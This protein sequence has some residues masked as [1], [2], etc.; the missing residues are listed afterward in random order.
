MLVRGLQKDP[1]HNVAFC[2]NQVPGA[3]S[4]AF[5]GS[6]SC[7]CSFPCV[8]SGTSTARK[9]VKRT[10]LVKKYHFYFFFSASSYFSVRTTS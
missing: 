6:L 2:G 4:L 1:G 3:C 7:G 10:N 8:I 9:Q 5:E